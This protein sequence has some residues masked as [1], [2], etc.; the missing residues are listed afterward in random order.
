MSIGQLDQE[1]GPLQMGGTVECC[2]AVP[3]GHHMLLPSS[4]STEL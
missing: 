1:G 4:L 2:H 3:T